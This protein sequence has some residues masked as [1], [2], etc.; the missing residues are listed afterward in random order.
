MST[1]TLDLG[2][3]QEKLDCTQEFT[4]GRYR[5]K[6]HEQKQID[7]RQQEVDDELFTL[8][9]I[10]KYRDKIKKLTDE[11]LECNK[12]IDSLYLKQNLEVII[13][14]RNNP[15]SIIN[16]LYEQGERFERYYRLDLSHKTPIPN[17]RDSFRRRYRR[18]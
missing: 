18:K 17:S 7:A 15:G 13:N 14:E 5:G 3:I 16:E 10:G 6:A 8:S 4:N 2:D 12:I 11:I 1:E 9:I